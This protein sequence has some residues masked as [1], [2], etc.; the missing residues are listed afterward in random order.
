MEI[1]RGL[2]RFAVCLFAA[3]KMVEPAI[4][5]RDEEMKRQ[6]TVFG[7]MRKTIIINLIN[8]VLLRG[9]VA[10]SGSPL[11][12]WFGLGISASATWLSG[13]FQS[14]SCRPA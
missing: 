3:Y 13:R 6:A 9:W 8:F 7:S 1:V 10:F 12:F 4:T 14:R 11:V 2:L 5:A